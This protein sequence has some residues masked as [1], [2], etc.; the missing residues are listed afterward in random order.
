ML[1]VVYHHAKFSLVRISPTA[2][3]AKNAEFRLFVYPSITLVN[4]RV[5]RTISPRRRWSTETT[6]T[7]L[8]RGRFVVVHSCSTLS[9]CCQLATPLNAEVQNMAKYGKIGAFSPPEDDRINLSRRNL[10]RKRRPWVCYSTPNLALIGKRGAI[11][12]P[13]KM[14]KFVQNC[15][16]CPLEADT[17]NTFR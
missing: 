12:E 3:A 5:V 1:E 17:M 2:G 15:G 10:A 7:P 6:L 11:Q 8:D 16:F 9:D 14:S 4:V 13:P